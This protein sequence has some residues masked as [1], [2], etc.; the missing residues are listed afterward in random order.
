[1]WSASSPAAASTPPPT[2]RCRAR[3]SEELIEESKP[4]AENELKREAVLPAIA[5]EEQFDV[6]DEEMAEALAHNAEHERTTPE[7][8][9][10]RLRAERRDALLREDIRVRKAIDLLAESAKPI[11]LAQ[12]EA[13]DAALDPGERSS[14]A[15]GRRPAL[16]AGERRGVSRP[17][18]VN[19]FSTATEPD[20]AED[21]EG[22]RAAMNRFGPAIG[23]S[24]LGGSVYDLPPG[25][26]ICPYHYEY[27]E[28]EWLLV[29]EGTATVRHPGGEDDFEP[30]DVVCFPSGP[31]GAHRISNGG[32]ER[33][34]V[35]ML[36]TKDP[37]GVSVY[38]D[39]DKIGVFPPRER[40]ATSSAAP[41]PS[42]TTTARSRPRP[43]AGASS[44]GMPLRT[45]LPESGST[46]VLVGEHVG[47]RARRASRATP[48]RD[49]VDVVA[50]AVRDAD[51]AGHDR[52]GHLDRDL[53]RARRAS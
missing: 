3:R 23:A 16:D 5:E 26:S 11:P 9:L 21:P 33:V 13:R 27:P 22:F 32:D 43:A 6:S 52:V 48:M 39:S 2:C 19:L 46:S 17:R 10:E 53:D 40:T 18:H 1:M 34:R 36:S 38:P 42:A 47:V 7:K 28:E 20:A 44:T 50:P 30:G 8:L 31:E 15:A 4:D 29:L 35:L 14:A 49:A 24:R 45:A 37:V 25:Q 51:D 12:A 41:A